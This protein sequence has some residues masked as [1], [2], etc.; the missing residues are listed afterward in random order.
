[1]SAHLLVSQSLM[2]KNSSTGST[3][4]KCSSRR[5]CLPQGLDENNAAK[6]DKIIGKRRW[7]ERNELLVRAGD[8]F[9]SLYIVHGGQFK[10][11]RHG[12][13]GKQHVMGFH[14]TGDILGL[15][16]ISTGVQENNATALEDSHV[17]EVPF[18]ELQTL[19]AHSAALQQH[20]YSILSEEIN[21][22]QRMM[23]F[24]GCSA[25]LRFATFL[26]DMSSRF[27]ARGY[28]P[29]HFTVLM[30]REDIGN[31]IG[32]TME[33]VSRLMSKF[34]QHGWISTAGRDLHIKN[35]GAIAAL[36]NHETGRYPQ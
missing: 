18:A 3:C 13:N 16:A 8:S 23:I 20:F 36:V 6:F 2:K 19:C 1:M 32:L 17:C 4:S 35:Y 31:Y 21:R 25:E 33:S 30:S 11:F 28:S 10:T 26:L 22:D 29:H 14:L 24:L 15:N 12:V 9:R 27:A 5:R 7:V 34:R